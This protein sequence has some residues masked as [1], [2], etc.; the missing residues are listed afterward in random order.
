MSASPSNSPARVA[1]SGTGTKRLWTIK[2]SSELTSQPT[3][4]SHT[5]TPVGNET[6]P[7]VAKSAM[8]RPPRFVAPSPKRAI[9]RS[10]KRL[11]DNT[12][13]FEIPAVGPIAH[14]DLASRQHDARHR[15][16]DERR[17]DRKKDK[18]CDPSR[19]HGRTSLPPRP[20]GMARFDLGMIGRRT[21][22]ESGCGPASRPSRAARGASNNA[23]GGGNF[24][25]ARGGWTSFPSLG[26]KSDRKR[27]LIRPM[28]PTIRA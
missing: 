9:D 13:G 23:V 25:A 17:T 22:I 15:A 8:D 6:P 12:S 24:D 10:P 18:D 1:A 11:T 26:P 2:P 27:P 3:G 20:V 5:G 4:R 21:R 28:A 7:P 16:H 19:L 14:G